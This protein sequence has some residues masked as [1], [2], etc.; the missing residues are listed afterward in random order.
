MW[1]ASLTPLPASVC[2]TPWLTL[3][4]CAFPDCL[5]AWGQTAWRET[6]NRH[7]ATQATVSGS[8]KALHFVPANLL[9]AGIAYEE[10]IFK[11]GQVPSRDNPH[12]FFNALIWLAFGKTKALLNR[13]Q[14]QQIAAHGIGAS[15]GKL[16]DFLT[17]FDENALLLIADYPAKYCLEQH[18]WITLLVKRRSDWLRENSSLMAIPFGHALLEKLLKP[19]KALT[20]HV[21]TITD[22][23]CCLAI[24]KNPYNPSFHAL[25]KTKMPEKAHKEYSSAFLT[26]FTVLSKLDQQVATVLEAVL[27]NLT[28]SNRYLHPLPVLG[29]P[30]WW[31]A[32]EQASFYED[33]QVFRPRRKKP[34]L[35]KLIGPD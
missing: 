7:A 21:W 22:L 28:A 2:N 18:D 13:W 11:S 3:L 23:K 35:A 9:P 4:N 27:P 14:A 16:R 32:N 30:G 29:I 26:A 20:A 8:G 5:A 24:K 17:V 15:R 31:P 25:S 33:T 34:Y 10:F 12:D 19:Y 6:F 1:P